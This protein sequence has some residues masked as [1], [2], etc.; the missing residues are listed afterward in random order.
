M[1]R[2]LTV[3]VTQ[4]DIELGLPIA[5][6]ACPLARAI[7][8]AGYPRVYVPDSRTWVP[9]ASLDGP[10]PR[11][12]LSRAAGRFVRRFDTGKPVKPATF[13]LPLPGDA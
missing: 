9:E 5:P 6:V 2:Y 8:R 1:T 10:S 13:R 4:E 7:R 3:H 12:T 11:A